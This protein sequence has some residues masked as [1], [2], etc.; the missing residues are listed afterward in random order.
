LN[1]LSLAPNLQIFVQLAEGVDAETWRHHLRQGDY[2]CWFRTRIK[3]DQLASD[4]ESIERQAGISTD[5]SRARIRELI[6]R[7]YIPSSPTLPIPGTD[8]ASLRTE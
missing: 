8:A 5:E 2:S 1:F 7:Y 3:D 6:E 4:A